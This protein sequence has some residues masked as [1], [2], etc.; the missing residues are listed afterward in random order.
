MQSS[1]ATMQQRTIDLSFPCEWKAEI[2][3]AAPM[4]SPA[5]QFVY[6]LPVPGEEDALAR[7]AMRLMVRPG[8]GQPA[9]LATC[10]LGFADPTMP[11]GVWSCPHPSELCAIAGGYA[12]I[13]NTE[14][15]EESLQ[16]PFRPVTEVRPL[17]GQG[18]LLFAGF[19]AL[20]ALGAHGIAWQTRRLSW[21]GV[22]IASVEESLLHGFGW[23]LMTDKEVP[24]TV[25][26]RT[27]EHTGG[28]APG[29]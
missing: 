27:G 12:Y 18:L 16:I 7:G 25:D 15:P 11:G 26:L 21:E 20:L 2:L 3:A 29:A 13:V 22:R 24:F 8:A 1:P 23:N 4:I 17:P 19:H 14:R 6:P 28:S 5:R 10:A 9:F